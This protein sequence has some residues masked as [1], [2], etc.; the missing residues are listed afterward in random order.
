MDDIF[1]RAGPISSQP[2]NKSMQRGA[3]GAGRRN[4]RPCLKRYKHDQSSHE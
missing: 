3:F 4:R 2:H 1:K